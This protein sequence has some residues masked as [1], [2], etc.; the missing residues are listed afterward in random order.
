MIIIFDL[1]YTL[2]DT[3]RF[4]NELGKSLEDCGVSSEKFWSS[5]EDVAKENSRI[6]DF[7]LEKALEPLKNALT[8]E[9]KEA[10]LRLLAVM[11]EMDTYLFPDALWLLNTLKEDGHS[12]KLFT[13]GNVAW[14]KMKIDAMHLEPFFDGIVIT[15]GYKEEDMNAFKDD[16]GSIVMIND[17]GEEIVAMKKKWP[18][19]HI[20]GI[21]G[22]KGLPNDPGLPV[23]KSLKEVYT[24]IQKL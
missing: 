6:R 4:K 21:P 2:L 15:E 10:K 22:P 5:Y 12:L 14:Q 19:M 18:D 23:A 1:D 8:C 20:I 9:V 3:A 16:M 24:I 13:H 11:E 17:N 7:N